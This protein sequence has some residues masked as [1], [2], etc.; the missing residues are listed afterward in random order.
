VASVAVLAG[1]VAILAW[2][3][4]GSGGEGSVPAGSGDSAALSEIRT[5]D[6]HSAAIHP[7]QPDVIL[8]GHH[9]G[10]L[11]SADGGR[12][13]EPTGLDE[14]GQDA[15]ALALSAADPSVVYAAGHDVFF[16]S[17]DGGMTWTAADSGLPGRD[18]HGFASAPDDPAR[19]YANVVGFGLFR[20]DDG[21]ATWEQVQA[22]ALDTMGLSAAAGG[23]LYAASQSRGVIRSNDGG[24]SFAA[25][26]ALPGIAVSVAAGSSPGVIY[27]GATTG[28]YASLDGGATWLEREL[29]ASGVPLVLTVNPADPSDI[30]VIVVGDDS[31]G[32]VYRSG[33]GGETWNSEE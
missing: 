13:W 14:H 26:A 31:V 16:R 9:G 24:A 30:L 7:T 8:Y 3:L 6:F 23:V 17:D 15:M 32:R 11:R 25:T 19:L 33:D 27:A 2:Q 10:V 5:P 29:P 18:I 12:T 22:N 28:V 20:S 4:Q 1:A 21:G